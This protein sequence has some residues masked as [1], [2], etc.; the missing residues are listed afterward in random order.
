MYFKF[1]FFLFKQKRF[2]MCNRGEI[3]LAVSISLVVA[4]F[5]LN[6]CRAPNYK[7]IELCKECL[8]ILN[9]KAVIRSDVTQIFYNDIIHCIMFVAYCLI[10]DYTSAIEY[11]R[12]FLVILHNSGEK[13]LE[14]KLS[15]ELANL[16]HHRCKHSEAKTLC[17]KAKAICR[18]IGE[19]KGEA[20]SNESLGTIFLSL[21]EY[22]KATE[23]LE[24]SLE[25]REEIGDRIGL[26]SC[27]GNLGSAFYFRGEY[28]KAK[29]YT[30]KALLIKKE[31]DDRRGEAV[32]YG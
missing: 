15:L 19:R 20:S 8:Y 17:W 14:S 6:T 28:R 9:N 5:L 27:Y 16:Y 31:N 21:G 10:N 4:L 18:E 30:E 7:T 3:R 23:N 22:I 11:G 13:A 1:N 29:E 26:A 25:I 2:G 24:R 32:C 12:K